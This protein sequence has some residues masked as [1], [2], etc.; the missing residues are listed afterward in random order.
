MHRN[1]LTLTHL[2]LMKG[3]SDDCEN[4][5]AAYAKIAKAR[6]ANRMMQSSKGWQN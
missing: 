5:E 3:S 4:R 1:Y 6:K 2:I